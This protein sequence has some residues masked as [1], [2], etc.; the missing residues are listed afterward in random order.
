MKK[1]LLLVALTLVSIWGSEHSRA[2]E[3]SIE[4]IELQQE[5]LLPSP[6][7]G[8]GAGGEGDRHNVIGIA[9]KIPSAFIGEMAIACS[10]PSPSTRLRC[11]GAERGR[12]LNASAL[13][14]RVT[15]RRRISSGRSCPA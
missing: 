9:R 1:I 6:Q 13:P 12:T 3:G 4:R 14:G 15:R 7:R 10:A 11:A 8:R 5:C 2:K